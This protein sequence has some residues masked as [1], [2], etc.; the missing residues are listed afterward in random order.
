MM[1]SD[2]RNIE[3][4]T[5]QIMYHLEICFEGG[6]EGKPKNPKYNKWFFHTKILTRLCE[7]C[8]FVRM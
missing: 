8:T 3:S 7:I 6:T 2:G 4:L 5:V 1:D